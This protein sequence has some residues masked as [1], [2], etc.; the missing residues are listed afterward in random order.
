MASVDDLFR[1]LRARP[2][3]PAAE[4]R[5]GL[6]ISP[7]RL[8]RLLA[9]AGEL[10]LRFGKARSTSYALARTIRDLGVSAP[11][12]E[13]GLDGAPRETG[14]LTFLQPDKY[15]LVYGGGEGIREYLPIF[16]KES[17][18]AGFLGRQF[19]ARHP[20]LGLPARLDA[21]RAEDYL[22][23][24]A[25]RGEDAVGNLVVGTESMERF[26]RLEEQ[27]ADSRDYPALAQGIPS[28]RRHSSAGGER[29]KFTAMVDGRHVLVKVAHPGEGDEAVRWRDLL[30][31]EHLAL[32][33]IREAGVAQ[34][35]ESRCID[36]D[37]WRFL[38]VVRFDRVGHRGRVG[39]R[40]LEAVKVEAQI[41]AARWTDAMDGLAG[42]LRP[43]VSKEDASRVRWLEAFGGLTGNDDR[44]DGN[45]SFLRDE[46]GALS[47]APAYDTAP[48]AL[49]PV[50]PG[51][52]ENS[53]SPETLV[54]GQAEWKR[55]VPW[56]LRY[57]DLL[58][59]E[60]RL[61]LRLRQRAREAR[62][63]VERLAA[64]VFP[65]IGIPPH[66]DR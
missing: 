19:S 61:E 60:A 45:V 6:G 7:S 27:P 43:L 30:L 56:A 35:A 24:I 16:L 23:A 42:G 63:A 48:M 20:E 8:S 59:A 38:E 18:P 62:G 53:W 36:L 5:R 32:E 31:C 13:V 66:P 3:T 64:R 37:G 33:V 44:H 26:L 47:L 49:A 2:G 34:A 58:Q 15:W 29:P 17:G 41:S 21:W 25:L 65:G 12:F 9:E 52:L 28:K 50:A 39:V 1:I 14:R 4:L 57:W 40:S 10:V 51:V 46:K 11:I 22:R 55:A 54:A